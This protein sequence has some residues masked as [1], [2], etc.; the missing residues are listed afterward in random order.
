MDGTFFHD[1]ETETNQAERPLNPWRKPASANAEAFVGKVISI[2]ESRERMTGQRL[3]ARKA[4]DQVVFEAAISALVADATVNLL[5]EDSSG[6]F[7]SRSKSTLGRKTRYNAPT[8]SKQLPK[9][10]DAL[11][12]P[13]INLLEQIV[14][15]EVFGGKRHQTIIRASSRLRSLAAMYSVEASDF[16]LIPHGEPI[17]LKRAKSGYWDRGGC[18]E[19]EDDQTTSLFRSQVELINQRLGAAHL[20]CFQMQHTGC[21]RPDLSDRYVR[22]FFSE[23]RFDCGGRLFGGFWQNLSK[24]DRFEA[25][26]INGEEIAEIDY[27]QIMPRLM[28]ALRGVSPKMDDLYA[29]PGYE[30]CRPGIKKVM[31][32]SLFVNKPLAR[33]PKGTREMFPSGCKIADVTKA[34]EEAH[35][36][37]AS[38]LYCGMGHRCQFLESEILVSVLLQLGNAGVTALPIHDAVLVPQSA[39]EI[40]RATML[41]VFREKTGAEGQVEIMNAVV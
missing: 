26:K 15:G 30:A 4:K 7:L 38:L 34:I 2:V 9:I 11:A 31:S 28:Y 22:R 17:V 39:V 10:L 36:A 41:S 37:I 16:P 5:Q 21:F 29:I 6:L 8:N 13:T 33:F 25:I 14:G 20:D 12:S 32:S 1:Q 35:P 18:V 3:R 23:D 24:K 19:Y 40:A 27:G